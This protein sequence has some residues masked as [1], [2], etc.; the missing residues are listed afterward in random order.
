MIICEDQYRSDFSFE[1]AVYPVR[2]LL[3]NIRI[4]KMANNVLR[5]PLESCSM[6]PVTGFFRDG[7]C[8]TGSE[9]LGL[10]LVCCEMTEDFL[11]FSASVGNDLSTSHPEMG[12]VGLKPGQ[13]WC[14]CVQR[15]KQAF[16]SGVAPRVNLKATHI[17]TLEFV[18]LEDLQTHSL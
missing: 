7:C 13:H 8:H 14:L 2:T 15:W 12:F 11:K 3:L 10:H 17:S 4:A 16:E 1:L 9:D 6:D 18:D 5:G